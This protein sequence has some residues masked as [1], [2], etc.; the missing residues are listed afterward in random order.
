LNYR[1]EIDGLRALAVLPVILFHAG[2]QLFSGG[3]VGVD[4]FFVISGYLITLIIIEDID[5]KRFSLIN[6]YERRA[7]RILP[8]LFFVI[9][10]SIPFAW[11]W[12]LPEQMKGYSKSIVSTIFFASNFLFWRE[13]GYFDQV[14][15][16]KPFLHTWSLAVEEQYYIFFPIFILL[17]LRF[18]K[19]RVFWAITFFAA[20]SLLLSEWGWRNNP[21]GNFYLAPTRAWELLVGSISAFIIQKN[22]VKSRG[23]LAMFGLLMILFSIFFYSEKTPFPSFYAL[24]PVVG[25]ALLV[26][27]AGKETFVA[28]ILSLRVFVGIGLVSYS[29]YLW[30]QPLFAFTRI[31]LEEAPNQYVLLSLSL[32][33]ILLAIFTWKYIEKPF[34]NKSVIK[35]KAFTYLVLIFSFLFISF[36]LSGYFTNGFKDEKSETFYSVKKSMNDD[37]WVLGDSHADHLIYGLKNVS[38]GTIKDF[39]SNGCIPLRNIDRYDSRTTKG[40][41]VKAMNSYLDRILQEDPKAIILISSMGPVYLDGTTYKGKGKA[42]IKGLNVE[43]I[44]DMSIKDKWSVYEIGLKQTLL[45]LS[46]LKNSRVI[47]SFDVPELGI[48][49]GCAFDRKI[50]KTPYF[51]IRDFVPGIYSG[52][53]FTLKSNYDERVKRYKELVYSILRDFPK[54]KVFDPTTYFCFEKKCTGFIDSVGYLY[55]DYDHLSESGSNYFAENF[56]NWLK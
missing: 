21:L 27:Y 16:E 29:A 13:S 31:K 23:T 11:M 15:E 7:R 4:I 51:D 19:N 48:D 24:V 17:A 50:I 35:I 45:E 49:G 42:R 14:T 39:T 30:H 9:L 12:M 41:C 5:N 32:A 33:S 44:S 3:Y 52:E 43:L 55:R 22:G 10:I 8:T 56:S 47:F 28:R 25:T 53:C 26:L 40:E 18:G 38:S 34:R 37:V 46:Q 20:A 6:F 2:F 36:A 54:I 1:P